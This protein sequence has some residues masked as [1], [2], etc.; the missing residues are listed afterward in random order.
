MNVPHR[1][2]HRRRVVYAALRKAFDRDQ[3]I[4]KLFIFWDRTFATLEHFVIS[5]YVEQ[6]ATKGWLND[7]EKRELTRALM[8]FMSH[9]Y[10][11]LAKYPDEF[12]NIK[13]KNPL[14]QEVPPK[15]DLKS[16]PLPVAGPAPVL[17]EIPVTTDSPVVK[18]VSDSSTTLKQLRASSIRKVTV[19][20]D[21]MPHYL[22]FR[23]V[24]AVLLKTLAESG[25]GQSELQDLVLRLMGELDLGSLEPVVYAWAEEN[26]RL[27]ALPVLIDQPMTQHLVQLFYRAACDVSAPPVT[28]VPLMDKVPLIDRVKTSEIPEIIR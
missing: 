16:T 13:P 5:P 17:S 28:K 8:H 4:P 19:T 27:E 20:P 3:R 14:V 26:F 18:D 1:L 12:V 2:N 15:E 9:D 10:H 21:M 25:R 11:E 22:V 23:E 24:M 7:Q 6:A